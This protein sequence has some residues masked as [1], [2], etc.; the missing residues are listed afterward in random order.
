MNNANRMGLN[1][2]PCWHPRSKENV[3]ERLAFILSRA[4]GEL[5]R[6]FI[7]VSLKPKHCRTKYRNSHLTESN[8]FSASKLIARDFMLLLLTMSIRFIARLVLSY[9][10]LFL[11]NPVWSVSI[12]SAI[13]FSSLLTIVEV[14]IL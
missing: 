14:N 10:L 2:Q 5:L 1:R 6:H 9:V 8:V 7:T 4:V 13:I 12:K 11:I 3:L